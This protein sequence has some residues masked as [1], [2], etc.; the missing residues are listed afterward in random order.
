MGRTVARERFESIAQSGSRPVGS[1]VQSSDTSTTAILGA[2]G[3]DWVIIDREHGMIELEA[4]VNHIRTA[5]AFGMVPI[6]RVLENSAAL[7]QQALDAGGQGIVVPKVE[8]AEDARRAVAA[9]QYAPGGRGMCPIVPGA[10][11]SAKNWAAF[12][13]SSNENVLTIPTIE[14]K[15]GVDN[16]AEIAAVEGID[17]VFFGLADLSQDLGIDMLEDRDELVR[18][19]ELV[20]RAAHAQNVRAGAPL[21]YGY[22]SLAD[23]GTIKSDLSMLRAAA[24]ER[25][26]AFR[27]SE[28]LSATPANT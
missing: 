5:D 28:E 12:S 19:W 9:S 14:T 10:D 24:E 15:M 16:I 13:R 2:V 26:D 4:M 20:A 27:R 17:Y 22:D 21:G 8:S 7:I 25:I 1:Y 23:F 18:L 11:Y 3:F 6:I